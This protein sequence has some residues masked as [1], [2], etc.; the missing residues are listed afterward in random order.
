MAQYAATLNGPL[1]LPCRYLADIDHV[2]FKATFLLL[3]G[4]DRQ[5]WAFSVVLRRILF[6]LLANPAMKI[7]GFEIGGGGA[8]LLLHLA[9][10]IVFI[11]FLQRHIGEVAAIRA[12]WLL[13]TYPG[14]TYWGVALFL[15]RNCSVLTFCHC[16]AVE[17]EQHPKRLVGNSAF[18]GVGS[19]VCRL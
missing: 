9:T 14:L 6:P 12:M 17:I 1:V 4:A 13:A 3:A 11:R 2:H 15:F 5:D 7:W 19:L 16:A 10:F 18:I 8:G